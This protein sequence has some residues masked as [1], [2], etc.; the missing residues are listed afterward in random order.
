MRPCARHR[1]AIAWLTLDALDPRTAAALREHLAGCVG[2]RRYR[3]E[4][5]QVTARLAL[6]APDS[7]LEATEG[8][9]RRLAERLERVES[10]SL[11]EEMAVWLRGAIFDWRVAL[12]VSAVLVAAVSL[13][14]ARGGELGPSA[15]VTPVVRVASPSDAENELAP[16]LANYQKVTCQSLEK[17]D[18]LLTEQGN[19]R[20]PPVPLYTVSGV[21]LASVSF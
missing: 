3:E 2:C 21:D 6:P 11:P 13:W 17:L 18:E 7:D 16:T 12:P 10:R 9:H 5:S 19:R 20:L 4:L 8:F 1:R 15:P 14:I